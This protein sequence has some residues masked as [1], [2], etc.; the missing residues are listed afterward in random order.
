MD[1]ILLATLRW[2][3]FS[4]IFTRVA[5]PND[6][7]VNKVYLLDRALSIWLVELCDRI[8]PLRANQ[9]VVR[10]LG[11]QQADAAK[12]QPLQ[13]PIC[14]RPPVEMCFRF[15]S[16]IVNN[17]KNNVWNLEFVCRKRDC[18]TQ[19]LLS[20]YSGYYKCTVKITL[21]VIFPV[22]T[23]AASAIARFDLL[24]HSIRYQC[25]VKITLFVILLNCDHVCGI[26]YSSIRFAVP[27][28]RV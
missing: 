13:P 19:W 8:G 6:R 9:V 5:C 3:T 1:I 24:Y 25:T 22:I 11:R 12:Q 10:I 4:S 23:C 27:W 20:M 18:L 7:T 17:N 14:P 21:F 15:W 16:T 26:G 2:N 28:S